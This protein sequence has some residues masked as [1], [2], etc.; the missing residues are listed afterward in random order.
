MAQLLCFKLKTNTETMEKITN[1]H[2]SYR[3]YGS[4]LTKQTSYTTQQIPMKKLQLGI[5]QTQPLDLIQEQMN[6]NM[7]EPIICRTTYLF[8]ALKHIQGILY[9][10]VYFKFFSSW[11][12]H[13]G[14]E[15]QGL[16]ITSTID[17]F[18]NIIQNNWSFSMY[19]VFGGSNFGLYAGSDND[20]LDSQF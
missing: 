20:E 18:E 14:E 11:L 2:Y 15:W 1:C 10:N 5:F 19:M 6:T 7:M 17:L 4:Q 8:S 16:N 13:W 9:T 3:K 12:T